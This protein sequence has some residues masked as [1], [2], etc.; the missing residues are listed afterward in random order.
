[1]RLLLLGACSLLLFWAPLVAPFVQ[2]WT[3]IEA[4]LALR[5]AARGKSSAGGVACS[6]G[7]ADGMCGKRLRALLAAACALAGFVLF[8]A[9]EYL[10]VA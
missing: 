2:G 3:L 4:C 5:G 1:M 9:T 6:G 10:W 8:L 7:S